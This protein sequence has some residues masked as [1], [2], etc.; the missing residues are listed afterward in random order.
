MA[1]A[2]LNIILRAIKYHACVTIICGYAQVVMELTHF[3][4][5]PLIYYL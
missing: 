4:V 3:K 1:S 2:V 5:I